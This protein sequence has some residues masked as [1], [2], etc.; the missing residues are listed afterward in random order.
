MSLQTIGSF[1]MCSGCQIAIISM[2]FSGHIR[3]MV[4]TGAIVGV[5]SIQT[6]GVI[7]VGRVVVNIL[8]N[9][10]EHLDVMLGVLLAYRAVMHVGGLARGW[11]G[12][13]MWQN[14]PLACWHVSNCVLD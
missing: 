11:K 14:C 7:S 4:V 6:S 1:S 9:C 8:H 5:V 2:D 13:K 10:K 12:V 3:V